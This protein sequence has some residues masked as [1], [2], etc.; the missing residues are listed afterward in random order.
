MN[1]SSGLTVSELHGFEDIQIQGKIKLVT[2]RR[3]Q[4]QLKFRKPKSFKN[5]NLKEMTHSKR[6]GRILMVR[7]NIILTSEDYFKEVIYPHA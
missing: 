7:I 6:K 5:K 2:L 1:E 3:S 4:T